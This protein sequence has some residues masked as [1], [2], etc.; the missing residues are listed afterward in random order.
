MIKLITACTTILTL[1]LSLIVQRAIS[2][3]YT[4]HVHGQAELTIAFE[5]EQ[6]HVDFVAPAQTLLGFEHK[7]S[8][9]SEI[10][11][12]A[13]TKKYFA[14]FNNI[15]QFNSGRCQ[16]NK[17]DIAIGLTNSETDKAHDHAHT[18]TNEHE[19]SKTSSH[20]EVKAKYE[21]SCQNAKDITSA[22]IKLFKQYPALEK[23]DV[24][25]L[26]YVQQGLAEVFP[27]NTS[28]SFN[29]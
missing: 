5:K 16:I 24:I 1:A 14:Q 22:S 2:V 29:N 20:S 25:W 15:I 19:H 11:E 10:T 26:G 13:N 9:S 23:V 7:A 6:V 21:L 4:A 27:E 18:D 17:V 3:E 28:I 8:S 12:V